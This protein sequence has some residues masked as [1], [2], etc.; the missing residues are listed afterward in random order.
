LIQIEP[1]NFH[2][3]FLTGDAPIH[4]AFTEWKD[5]HILRRQPAE[6]KYVIITVNLVFKGLA[7]VLRCL[8]FR[9]IFTFQLIN[10]Q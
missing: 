1:E 3:F 10:Q 8:C 5:N 2:G 7:R 6:I 4:F 9:S